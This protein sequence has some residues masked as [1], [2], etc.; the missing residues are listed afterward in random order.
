MAKELLPP[1]PKIDRALIDRLK[2]RDMINKVA[3]AKK[4]NETI[5]KL[6]EIVIELIQAGVLKK[7]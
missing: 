5:D 1:I 4:L 7:E 3:I 2:G 6:E